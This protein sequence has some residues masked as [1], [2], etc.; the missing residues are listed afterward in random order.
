MTIIRTILLAAALASLP[1]SPAHAADHA[2]PLINLLAAGKPAIGV[3]TNIDA[4]AR[5]TSIL[6]TS[7]ADFLVADMEHDIYDFSTLQTFL[8]RV[9]DASHRFRAKPRVA[10]A[11]LV[12]LA[13]RA[14]WDS[15]Y[16]ISAS[17]KAGLAYGVWVPYVENRAD[18]ER[19]ISAVRGVESRNFGPDRAARD[20]W[21]LNP[22][23]EIVVVAM[24][25]SA[26]GVKNA[27]EIISTPGVTA[28]EPV[29]LSDADTA[30]IVEL[31][32][33]KGVF[34]AT[35]VPPAKTKESIAAG[36]RLISAGWDSGLLQTAVTGTLEAMREGTK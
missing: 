17:L 27:E 10:P 34:A 25:E 1:T 21:P 19:A 8:L 23:G 22:K 31:C 32:K 9:Q 24:I 6:A 2:N 14:T 33:A 3:W 20:V 35:T 18:L 29:H 30:R 36:Y 7:D 16:D 13:H 28:I 11:V 12:K 5:A 4:S 26:E 15:R